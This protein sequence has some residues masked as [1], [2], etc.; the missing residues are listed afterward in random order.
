M[1]IA[2]G[3]SISVPCRRSTSKGNNPRI[4]VDAVMI[5]GRTRPMHA[6]RS[7]S[8]N[9]RRAAGELEDPAGLQQGE[10]EEQDAWQAHTR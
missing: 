6:S 8:S 1:T 2:S 4:A 3:R 5:L 10:H 9:E 7:A